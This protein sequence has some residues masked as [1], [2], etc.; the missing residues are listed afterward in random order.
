MRKLTQLSVPQ[1]TDSSNFPD[2]AII[3]ETTLTSGTPVVEEVYGDVL[4]NVY[5]LLREAGIDA[6]GLQ[7]N[8]TNGYQVV[9]A[10]KRLPN[11][12]NDIIHPLTLSVNVWSVQV[13][14]NILPNNYFLL[15][16]AAEDFDTSVTYT[17]RGSTGTP[18]LTFSSNSAFSAGDTILLKL[19]STSVQA[20]NIT[21]SGIGSGTNNLTS[22]ITL[23]P[24]DNDS[25]LIIS[26]ENVNITID[27][28]VAYADGFNVFI[29]VRATGSAEIDTDTSN[30]DNTNDLVLTDDS[31][32][33]L[34]Y[35]QSLNVWFLNK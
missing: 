10:L 9:E 3:N 22:D 30:I 32:S 11:V 16:T 26:S 35:S 7:D 4:T 17:F 33:L 2:G 21:A 25:V 1:N 19:T 24:S 18:I 13:D 20:V 34:I 23:S 28:N 14:L 31:T 27:P 15:V 12:L 8:N 29:Q 6:S 5:N